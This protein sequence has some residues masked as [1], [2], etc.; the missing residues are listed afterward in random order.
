MSNLRAQAVVLL[1]LVALLAVS[2]TI[3]PLIEAMDSFMVEI[4]GRNTFIGVPLIV[5]F[6]WLTMLIFLFNYSVQMLKKD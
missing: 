3:L 2:T 5:K 1:F 4:H 6:M